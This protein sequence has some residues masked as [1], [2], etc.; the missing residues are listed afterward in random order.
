MKKIL[1][2][3]A[4]LASQA[5]ATWNAYYTAASSLPNA[6]SDSLFLSPDAVFSNVANPSTPTPAVADRWFVNPLTT[7][8]YARLPI[9]A[10]GATSGTLGFYWD[11]TAASTQTYDVIRI[12]NSL[13]V[14]LLRVAYE[15]TSTRFRVYYGALNVTNT[16]AVSPLINHKIV[17]TYG[18]S[19]S[20]Q[21]DSDTTLTNTQVLS[22]ATA[23]NFYVG[24]SPVL[25]AVTGATTNFIDGFGVSNDSTDSFPPTPATVTSTQTSTNTITPSVTPTP[26]NT[27]TK[28]ITP[29]GS[30]TAS[31]TLTMTDTPTRTSTATNTV[32]PSSTG[33]KTPTI[34][35][36]N[37]PTSTSTKTPTV[38][39][40]TTYTITSTRTVSAT[41][42][43]T[44]TITPSITVTPAYTQVLTPV[45]VP[46]YMEAGRHVIMDS[47]PGSSPSN[48]LFYVL[49]L[50]PTL[51]VTPTKTMTPT[52]TATP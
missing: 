34:T 29:N 38:T 12:T 28:T 42:T 16:G 11:K 30:Q 41:L 19:G 33:T 46:N 18:A 24:G 23:A 4:F 37:T 51:T 8:G 49:V 25:G 39:L 1:L 20:I 6:A 10:L 13:G 27:A 17:L 5:H 52:P 48:P 7:A 9:S 44:P 22:L 3:L 2:G 50:T 40:T 32:T 35:P 45:W 31:D 36:S 21:V 14:T 43:R 15:G 47:G 26:T